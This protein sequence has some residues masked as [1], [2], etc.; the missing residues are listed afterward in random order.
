MTAL[1]ESAVTAE[2]GHLGKTEMLLGG[3]LD[4]EAAPLRSMAS[5]RVQYIQ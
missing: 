5:T 2:R 1:F 3:G 4:T